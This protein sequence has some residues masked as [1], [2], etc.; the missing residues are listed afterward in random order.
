MIHKLIPSQKN[1]NLIPLD[2]LHGRP[3]RPYVPLSSLQSPANIFVVESG[4][5]VVVE[6]CPRPE[7][8]VGKTAKNQCGPI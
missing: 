3:M 1:G 4:G 2:L 8:R 7:Y 6:T 5:E